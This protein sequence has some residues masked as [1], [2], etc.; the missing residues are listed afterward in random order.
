MKLFVDTANGYLDTSH[1]FS[2]NAEELIAVKNDY[3]FVN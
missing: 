3:F 2:N 1:S